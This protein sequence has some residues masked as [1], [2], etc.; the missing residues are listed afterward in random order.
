MEDDW[1][2]VDMDETE[3]SIQMFDSFKAIKTR[4]EKRKNQISQYLTFLK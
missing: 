2:D 1:F 3:F 4:I